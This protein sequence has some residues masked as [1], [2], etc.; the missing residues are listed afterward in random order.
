MMLD[1]SESISPMDVSARFSKN[2]VESSSSTEFTMN[3]NLEEEIDL[4][5]KVSPNFSHRPSTG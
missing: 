2:L 3:L 1:E 4:H 5:L